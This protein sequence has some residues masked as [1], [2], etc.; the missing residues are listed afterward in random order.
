M[1]LLLTEFTPFPPQPCAGRGHAQ[2][3]RLL[4]SENKEDGLTGLHSSSQKRAP[5]LNEK[6][7]AEGEAVHTFSLWQSPTKAK[8]T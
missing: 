8:F 6:G 1:S 7:R 5:T 3:I 4:E 2:K